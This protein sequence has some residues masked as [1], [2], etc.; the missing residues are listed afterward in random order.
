MNRKEQKEFETKYNRSNDIKKLEMIDILFHSYV[1]KFENYKHKNAGQLI[2]VLQSCSAD[3]KRL[4]AGLNPFSDGSRLRGRNF[5]EFF[6]QQAE[7]ANDGLYPKWVIDAYIRDMGYSVEEIRAR[8]GADRIEMIKYAPIK[9]VKRSVLN[10]DFKQMQ[11]KKVKF[12]A[13]F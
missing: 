7:K 11:N 1:Y 3:W 8:K 5:C 12:G 10:A 13:L 9:N 6:H 4:L 2:G